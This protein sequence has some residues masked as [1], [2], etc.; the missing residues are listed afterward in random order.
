MRRQ[1]D[2][3]APQGALAN[4]RLYAV[5]VFHVVAGIRRIAGEHRGLDP[6]TCGTWAQ[7]RSADY[8]SPEELPP[9]GGGPSC[10]M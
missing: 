10:G 9:A 5:R 4:L 3:V 2:G 7:G 8:S 6:Y 1:G